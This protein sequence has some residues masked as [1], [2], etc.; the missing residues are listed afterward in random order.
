MNNKK[1][2]KYNKYQ[3]PCCE[4]YTLDEGYP[5]SFNICPVCFWED[6]GV[7]FDERDYEGGA[8]DVSLNQAKENFKKIRACDPASINVVRPPKEI[9]LPDSFS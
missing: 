3:C 9:E 2:N 1:K 8:N 7:Q 6:D 4:Y 5:N